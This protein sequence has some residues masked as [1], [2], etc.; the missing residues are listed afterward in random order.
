MG[1]HPPST[2]LKTDI[3][4]PNFMKLFASDDFPFHL[5]QFLRQPSPSISGPCTCT[6]LEDHPGTCKWL[7][8]PLCITLFSM[9]F[10]RGPITP[11]LWELMKPNQRIRP[12]RSWDPI[13]P[14][15][16]RPMGPAS[17]V[18]RICTKHLQLGR[19][20]AWNLGQGDPVVNGR[21]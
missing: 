16:V 10:G 18:C 17:Y 4:N 1:E 9:P 20:R 3:L 2:T 19:K 13:H 15:D 14:Q 21:G 8:S 12:V 6:L 5:C 11:S 7:G